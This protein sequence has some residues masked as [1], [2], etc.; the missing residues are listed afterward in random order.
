MIWITFGVGLFLGVI[1]GV[2]LM[3]LMTITKKEK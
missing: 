1:V 2:F 3:A